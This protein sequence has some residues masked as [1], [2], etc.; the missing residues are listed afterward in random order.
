M[1]DNGVVSRQSLNHS[2]RFAAFLGASIAGLL[3]F[4]VLAGLYL[5]F[6]PFWD[7]GKG[8]VP[9]AV[10][11]LALVV[12]AAPGYGAAHALSAAEGSGIPAMGALVTVAALYG[13]ALIPFALIFG[14]PIEQFAPVEADFDFWSTLA[15]GFAAVA[16][17]ITAT[18]IVLAAKSI[19]RGLRRM[20]AARAPD[21]P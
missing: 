8:L 15:L 17:L 21:K 19:R 7:G 10:G 4:G 11:M 14:K 13:A 20:P 16:G 3:A 1:R 9:I 18:A 12:L 5:G 2:I 6:E